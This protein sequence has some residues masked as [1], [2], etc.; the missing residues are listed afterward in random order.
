S[1]IER[2]IVLCSDPSE[3]LL[4]ASIRVLG[5]A[6][7]LKALDTL[8]PLVNHKTAEVRDAALL[9]LKSLTYQD[10]DTDSA[11]WEEWWKKNRHLSRDRLIEPVL[12]NELAA[13]RAKAKQM[14]EQ[15]NGLALQIVE[16]NPERA[17]DFLSWKEPS[18]RRRAAEAI[19][20]GGEREGNQPIMAKVIGHLEQ[21][22]DDEYTLKFL[23]KFIGFSREDPATAQAI[24]LERLKNDPRDTIK[25]AAANSL[26]K[27]KHQDIRQAVKSLLSEL[28]EIRNRSELKEALLDLFAVQGIGDSL[29]IVS[30]Y[31]MS[32]DESN[33]G[34]RE[35]AARALGA[36]RSPEAIDILGG[37]LVGEP[38]SNIRAEIASSLL[39][40]GKL[41]SPEQPM[42]EKAAA[43]LGRGLLDRESR[44]KIAC[45][46]GIGELKPANGLE[47]LREHLIRSDDDPAVQLWCIKAIGWIGD[48]RGLE[49]IADALPEGNDG[50][51]EEAMIAVNKICKEDLAIWSQAVELFFARKQYDL[52]IH[53]CDN[54]V[55]RTKAANGRDEPLRQVK[56]RRAE[57]CFARYTAEGDLER[58]L[59][60]AK[61]L[62][63][64]LAPENPQFLWDQARTLAELKR[65]G[66]AAQAYQHLL[67]RPVERDADFSVR[68]RIKREQADA[69]LAAGDPKAAIDSLSGRAD[70]GFST[71]P[72]DLKAAISRVIQEAELAL[73]EEQ[74][75]MEM[76]T[77]TTKTPEVLEAHPDPVMRIEP[78]VPADDASEKPVVEEPIPPQESEKSGEKSL[79]VSS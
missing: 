61:D 46:N 14:E 23:L 18:I 49:T 32:N 40:L 31:L 37:A 36:S 71:L 26:Q 56:I 21:G 3:E 35:K 38:E 4:L 17:V 59:E 27:F 29:T 20:Q 66:E 8:I 58:A 15:R 69:Y 1:T 77:K 62:A 2:L 55:S 12:A 75:G 78:A 48:P 13:C 44:V 25:V 22:E 74:P 43:A 63:E 76:E 7:E 47:V 64:Q 41:D 67:D 70:P 33:Q 60:H 34:V 6:C 16:T 54:Y 57:A 28:M 73:K 52:T 30:H 11:K 9:S 5:E 45:I 42:K 51:L 50:L 65:Y 72:E 39:R 53:C 10:F 68:W 19:F 24:L 79:G